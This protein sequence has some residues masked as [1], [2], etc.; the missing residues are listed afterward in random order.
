TLIFRRRTL[1]VPALML[2]L[3]ASIAIG[4][5]QFGVFNGLIKPPVVKPPII[6]PFPVPNNVVPTIPPTSVPTPKPRPTHALE[7]VRPPAP[8]N[9]SLVPPVQ[10]VENTPV[11]NLTVLPAV[12]SE[13][14]GSAS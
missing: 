4:S 2:L 12:T 13:S 6:N 8:S 3:L 9:Q 7:P 11:R 14:V 1:A 10:P 5:Y